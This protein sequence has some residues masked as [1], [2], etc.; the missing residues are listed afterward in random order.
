LAIGAAAWAAVAAKA[1]AMA[2]TTAARWV[3]VVEIMG[4]LFFENYQERYNTSNALFCAGPWQIRPAAPKKA[5][6]KTP[7]FAYYE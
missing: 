4:A 7:A 3:K 5:I 6:D 2:T 1:P